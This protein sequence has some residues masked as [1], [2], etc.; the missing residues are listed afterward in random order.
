MKRNTDVFF[1]IVLLRVLA[2]L[3]NNIIIT[4]IAQY[5]YTEN[6]RDMVLSEQC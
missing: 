3:V 4:E 6:I 1:C 5:R 2:S